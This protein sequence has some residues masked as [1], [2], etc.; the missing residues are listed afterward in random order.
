MST[1]NGIKT[2]AQWREK[3][4]SLY[5]GTPPS[6][7]FIEAV[8]ADALRAAGNTIAQPNISKRRAAIVVLGAAAS[9]EKNLP[10][11]LQ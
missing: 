7:R 1:I 11:D 9:L 5:L 3:A 8:Q 2:S 10:A 6:H 4:R